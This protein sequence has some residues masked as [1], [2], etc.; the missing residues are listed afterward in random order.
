M[1][2]IHPTAL[3]DPKAELATD[4]TVG[5]FSI[6]GPNV[7]I[8]SGTRI[9]SHTTVEGHTTLGEGNRIGPYASIGGTPQDMKYA[10]EPTRLEIGDRNTIREFTTIHT[11]TVQDRGLT[12]L[13]NDNWIMAY[14]H[15]AHDCDVGNHV[16]FSSNAQIAGHVQVGDWAIL[17]G[18]SGVHQ[19][20]RIGA[21]AFLGGASAL[22][23]D[24]PPFVI[25]AGDK[26]G[27]KATPHGVNVEGLRRRGFDAGQIAA[28]R[29]AYKLLYK[30]DL[31]FDDAR[32]E[33]AALLAQS[34]ATTSEP[35]RALADFLA[36][37]QRGIVR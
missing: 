7:R 16:V 22:V 29:Q 32:N 25:A 13:G 2:Q 6:V 31:N 5:P 19:F 23:Q 21:H 36:T 1:T 26:G 30:S 34:D 33:I 27:N 37:T 14:V 24:I 11:G 15:I 12:R 8:G 28:L 9:G 20:V 10:N 18:M 17:G 35:L 3:V 4:V